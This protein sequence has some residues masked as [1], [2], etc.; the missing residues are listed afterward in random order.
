MF[1]SFTAAA[2]TAVAQASA[3]LAEAATITADIIDGNL[4]PPKPADFQP[5]TGSV[6]ATLVDS[7]VVEAA[8][9][10]S[11]GAN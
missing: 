5:R 4:A 1:A 9:G 2:K 6:L 7:A 8:S 3:S 11:G 10:A